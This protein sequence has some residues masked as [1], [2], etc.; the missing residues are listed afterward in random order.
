MAVPFMAS[1]IAEWN[2]MSESTVVLN[3]LITLLGTMPFIMLLVCS[4]TMADGWYRL[5]IMHP[6]LLLRISSSRLVKSKLVTI[7]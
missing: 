3:L 7:R 4:A 1:N 6:L 2:I 5:V